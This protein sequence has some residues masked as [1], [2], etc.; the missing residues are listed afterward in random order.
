MKEIKSRF[1]THLCQFL[2]FVV[3][4]VDDH[5]DVAGC[6]LVCDL[7]TQLSL[8]TIHDDEHG[9]PRKDIHVQLK[10]PLSSFFRGSL[11]KKCEGK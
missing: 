7:W 8:T 1:R 2:L 9:G 4:I 10:Q 6:V 3:V 5:V 11:T